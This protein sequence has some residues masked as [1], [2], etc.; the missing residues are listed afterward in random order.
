MRDFKKFKQKKQRKY[1]KVTADIKFIKLCK[2]ER[3]I[4]TFPEVNLSVKSGSTK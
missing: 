2:V 4:Q 1:M 3:I